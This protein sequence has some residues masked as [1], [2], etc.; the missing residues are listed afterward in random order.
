[1]NA[2]VRKVA[3]AAMVLFA[4]L[5]LNVNYIQVVRA[6]AL[7]KDPGNTRQLYQE[8]DRERGSITVAGNPIAASQATDGALKYLRTYADGP[9][10]APVT[11]WYSLVSGTTGLEQ[12]EN[13]VLSGNDPRLTFRRLADLF[14]GRDPAGG[15][16]EL[17]LDPNVQKTAMD[18]LGGVTGA[19]VALD[20]ETGAVLGLASTPTYDP[21]QLS[22]HDP[23]AIRAY[24]KSI[25][26]EPGSG[27]PDPTFNEALSGRHSPGSVFK[28][29]VSAAALSTG[30]YTPD[31]PVPAPN[32]YTAPGTSRPLV[33]YNR[34]SCN[35]GADQP[36]LEAL[37][38]SC[39]TAFAQLGVTL[40]E[41]RIRDMAEAFGVGDDLEIPLP[42]E[43]STLGDIP[44][45]PALAQSS[46]GQRDVQFTPLQAAMVAATVANKGAE[47]KPYLV[48]SIQA[49]D[50]TTIDQTDPEKLGNPISEEVAGQLDQM[51]T[52]VV[53]GPRGTGKKAAIPGVKVAG[54]TGT[55]QTD[56]DA[57][58][59]SWFVGYADGGEGKKI[60]VAVFIQGGGTGGDKSAPL[61]KQVMQAYL[62]G[63]GAG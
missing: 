49:P 52:A 58:D 32:E 23:A 31:T 40:G 37:E 2:P 39:N 28:V 22:S 12:V 24:K 61:A 46:I 20:P 7:R 9:T 57:A 5:I 4:L 10:Y 33:N 51:M 15:N 45:Q 19:V 50:L 38:M 36:L 16:V 13:D 30:D 43:A 63:Q 41:D 27:K 56:P 62:S 59:N 47:M 18:G 3:I 34:E 11:G 8:Y 54:K 48:K 53:T 60:A 14:T 6:N 44:D 25:T 42:V 26:P 17:T 29:L 21:N 1:M 55:A 35:G